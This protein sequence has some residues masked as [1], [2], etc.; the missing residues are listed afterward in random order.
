[1]IRNIASTAL[2]VGFCTSLCSISI[3][4]ENWSYWRGPAYSGVSGE[5]NLPAEWDPEGGEG[6]NVVWAQEIPI[7]ATPT[8]MNG[9]LYALTTAN[10]EDEAL[11]GEKVVCI[12]AETGSTV[13]EHVFNVYLSDVP[14]ERIG[15]SSVACDPETGNVYALGVC[16]YFCC[17][18]GETGQLMWQH[19]Q[20]KS[21]HEEFGLLST[22]GGRTNF[23]IVHENNVIISAVTIG[24]GDTAK[25]AHRFIAFDK[26]NGVPVWMNGTS[27]LPDDTTYSAPV[28]AVI[29]GEL[30]MIFASGDGGIHSMHPRTGKILWSYFVSG[31]GVNTAPLVVGNRVYCGHGE[32]NLDTTDMG[33]VFCIDATKRGDITRTG[34]IWRKTGIFNGRSSPIMIDG[35]L[36]V[37]DDRAKLHCLDADTGESLGDPVRMGTMMRANLLYAD[38]K[39][40][41][42]EANGRGYIMT[43]TET[44]ADIIHKFRF[45]RGEE[46]HG[47][48]IVSEGR[49]FI[50]TTG[51]LYCIGLPDAE[52]EIDPLPPMPAETKPS[53]PNNPAEAQIVPAELLLRPGYRQGFHVR[54]YNDRGQFVRMAAAAEVQYELTGPGS[55]DDYGLFQVGRDV[56]QPVATIVNAKVG[57]LTT[58]A[59]VRTIPELPWAFDFSDGQIPLPWIGMA[60]RHVPLDFDLL[61]SLR[62]D[63]PMA[64][65]LYIYLMSEF[66]NFAPKRVFDDSSPQ[67]RWSALL[68]FLNIADGANRPK[69]VEAAQA[70]LGSSLQRLIDEKVVASADWTTWDRPT[71]E[72][73]VFAAEP[74]LTIQRGPRRI[75]GNGVLCKITT[76]PKGARSQGWIGHPDLHDYTIQSDVYA[77]ER[78]GKLPDIGLIAQRY[79]IDLMGASQQIQMRTWT[80]QLNRFSVNVPF[81][82]EADQWYTIKFS[83]AVE[84]NKAVLRGKVWKKGEEEPSE[85]MI[86]GVDEVPNTIGSPGFFG[87]AK[88]AEIF[89]DNLSVIRN[90]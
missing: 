84:D 22:Y 55:I 31:R 65:D 8:L 26:R 47:S 13:W 48:P 5:K 64:S 63:D 33:A 69:D 19:P 82:W 38:G 80:P 86:E 28:L 53:G 27:L 77:F 24:W 14:A 32:E 54:L 70:A 2:L 46:A 43:P 16:G 39:I 21:L 76:I 34:E 40:Y 20:Y 68:Q 71:S 30:Q 73:G 78:N 45:Q 29:D 59:R 42:H 88:D 66:E 90:N 7:R 89:Y 41:A 23:P 50:P 6:S 85:W 25:P 58:Q 44:G 67:L 15:W 62:K 57:N 37:A 36:Y 10:P 72:E 11:M 56:D 9:K 83:A 4:E 51:N 52:V 87:N 3:A 35:R 17:L 1:M 12:D 74:R 81:S 60:Y 61:M 79:T 49:I 75:D 18:N